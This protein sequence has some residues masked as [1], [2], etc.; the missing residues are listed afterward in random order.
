MSSNRQ[1]NT[2]T[3]Y[4]SDGK[5]EDLEKSIKV[6]ESVFSVNEKAYKLIN[7]TKFS[8]GESYIYKANGKTSQVIKYSETDRNYG[9]FINSKN[10]V[11]FTFG[12]KFFN[13]NYELD[14]VD[15]KG[16]NKLDFEKD[17]I[18]LETLNFFTKKKRI[19]PLEKPNLTRL[20]NDKSL[21]SKEYF[22]YAANLIDN[23]KFEIVTKFIASD[24]KSSV[25]YRNF[26]D[27]DGKS[28]GETQYNISLPEDFLIYGL[29][30]ASRAGKRNPNGV[31]IFW[32]DFGINDFIVDPNTNDVYVYGLFGNKSNDLNDSNAPKGYY[33][34]K[35]DK[36]GN[37][38]W[39]SM[40]EIIDKKDFNNKVHLVTVFNS[41]SFYSG[42]LYF[43]AGSPGDKYFHYSFL[44]KNDGKAITKKKISYDL[45]RIYTFSTDVKMFL[46]SFRE[47]KDFKN[48]VFD[49]NGLVALDTNKLFANYVKNVTSK[50][51]LYFST[52]F[53][54][55]GIWLIE[56]DND[57]Y[58]KVIYFKN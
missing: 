49:N 56:S 40:N 20:I 34:F 45:D 51:K 58:Y 33:I 46:F 24:Y 57:K 18:Y 36:N 17:K 29:N 19:L 38:L 4:N 42:N 15:A 30:E 21:K 1:I 6:N 55:E 7:F 8:A 23:D 11:N 28:I 52:E 9:Y 43:I 44:D 14:L 32:T 10:D 47:N 53:S 48:K 3:Q 50:N 5:I 27:M 26:Y 31:S 16:K 13:D 39:E 12:N 41:L 22:G 54:N 25:I 37:K 35:F 2:I